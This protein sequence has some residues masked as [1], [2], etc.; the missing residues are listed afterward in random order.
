MDKSKQFDFWFAVNNTEVIQMPQ[1]HLETF[2][3][4]VLNYHL[5]SELMD[6]VDQVRVRVG[7]MQAHQPQIITPSGYSQSLLEGFGEEARQY[8]D[9]LKEHEEQ[10]RIL[11]YGYTLRQEAFSEHIVSDNLQNVVD[12]VTQEVDER[13]D[14]L[15]AVAVGVDDPWDVC[16][17]KLF[18]EVVQSSAQTNIRQLHQRNLFNQ[19]PSPAQSAHRKIEQAFL[20]ASREPNQI[21]SLAKMLQEYRLF[22]Q[23]QDR[24]FSLVK[25]RKRKR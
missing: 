25:N 4:T 9:W 16:L 3:A 19:A 21:D 22:D 7:R 2:G 10:L 1:R 17:V 13:N 20:E 14:P 11:Q 15:S 6:R 18:W 8:V 23:Y 5:I 24:F 12:R